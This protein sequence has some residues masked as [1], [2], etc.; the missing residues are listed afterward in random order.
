MSKY[1]VVTVHAK[2]DEVEDAINY[3]FEHECK[4]DLQ[5]LRSYDTPI[6]V[7]SPGER[8]ID[9]KGRE[10]IVLR[11]DLTYTKAYDIARDYYDSFVPTHTLRRVDE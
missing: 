11:Q 7:F 3:V 5:I 8:V 2:F 1:Y 4:N 6:Q 10:Y 9:N